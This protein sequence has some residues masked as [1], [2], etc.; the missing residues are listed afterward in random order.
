MTI[1]PTPPVSEKQN[2]HYVPR[3]WLKGFAGPGGRLLALEEG[4]IGQV[5]PGNIMTEDWTY[6]IFD[7]WWR[8]SDALENALGQL[9]GAADQLFKDL[10]D[11]AAPPSAQGWDFLILFLALTACRH[12]DVMDRGHERS[13]ELG[14]LFADVHAYPDLASFNAVFKARYGGELSQELFDILRSK[15]PE[16]LV[17]EGDEVESLSPQDPRLPEQF[18]VLAYDR[19]AAKISE[20]RLS[21]LDAPPGSHFVLGD[22]AVPLHSVSAGFDVPLSKTLAF[23]ATPHGGG[24]PR[25]RRSAT[26]VEVE[27]ISQRQFA[28]STGIIIGPDYATIKKAAGI[29]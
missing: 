2:Q 10:R 18:S 14:W 13:K 11:N 21:L 27:E 3:F 9:E 6:T 15:S 17:A 12:P 8:P 29:P 23:Q 7:G 28:R 4:T 22:R 25:T 20:M 19:V 1:D 5:G 16:E 24:L 26:V